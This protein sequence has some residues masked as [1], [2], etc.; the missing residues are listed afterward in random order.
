MNEDA[1]VPCKE[2]SIEESIIVTYEHINTTKRLLNDIFEK[3]GMNV[4]SNEKKVQAQDKPQQSLNAVNR[5][6]D[7]L[8]KIKTLIN[9]LNQD[10]NCLDQEINRIIQPK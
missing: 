9:D 10:L 7:N 3:M 5:M 1:N 6:K 4:P 2:M 8:L